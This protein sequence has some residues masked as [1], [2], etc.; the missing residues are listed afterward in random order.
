MLKYGSNCSKINTNIN[1]HIK[2][3]ELVMSQTKYDM[4]PL[5]IDD[6]ERLITKKIWPS[7]G[8]K[9][10]KGGRSHEAALNFMYEQD[11]NMLK[12]MDTVI[13]AEEYYWLNQSD[14][15]VIF[16][17]SHNVITK[18]LDAK[19]SLENTAPLI[20]PHVSFIVAMP[21][22]YEYKGVRLPPVHVT[23]TEP[24]ERDEIIN[25]YGLNVVGMPIS[26]LRDSRYS[27]ER[28]LNLNYRIFDKDSPFTEQNYERVKSAFRACIPAALIP[29]ILR[30]KDYKEYSAIL[31]SFDRAYV[32]VHELNEHDQQVQ[33]LIARFVLMAGLYA[34]SFPGSLSVGYPGKEPKKIEPL[35]HKRWNKLALTMPS[36]QEGD[37]EKQYHY[38]SW[39]FRQLMHSKYYKGEHKKKPIGSR[40]VFVRDTS[41]GREIEPEVLEV[42]L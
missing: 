35:L 42:K 22:D 21:K 30:C 26:R 41:V 17:E 18:L 16:P 39:H 19:I 36:N 7:H 28:T 15:K 3:S 34:N 31:G 37:H 13:L 29:D 20:M 8:I 14:R 11:K 12:T 23:W 2:L 33:F 38:R 27:D 25:D 9:R 10:K 40:V 1:L 6:L 32:S 5:L 4:H 24:H